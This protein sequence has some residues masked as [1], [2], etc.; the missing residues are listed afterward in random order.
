MTVFNYLFLYSM[1]LNFVCWNARGLTN[2][3]KLK[4]TLELCKKEDII[5]LQETKWKKEVIDNVKKMWNDEMFYSNGDVKLG[6]GVAIL[7]GNNVDCKVKEIYNDG[8]GKCN[9]VEIS[10][11]GKEFILM[12]VHAPTEEKEKREFLKTLEE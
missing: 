9:A 4:N 7:I 8:K 2:M 1:V 3:N 5:V 12:N 11:G 6:S 10:H